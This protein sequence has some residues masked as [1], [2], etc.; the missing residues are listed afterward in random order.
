MLLK[1]RPER[2]R[3]RWSRQRGLTPRVLR[4]ASGPHPGTQ[5]GKGEQVSSHWRRPA[6]QAGTGFTAS[7]S[8][9]RLSTPLPVRHV[10]VADF[11][12]LFLAGCWLLSGV[13]WNTAPGQVDCHYQRR[14]NK[15]TNKQ[16]RRR[17]H[18]LESA[19]CGWRAG[20]TCP[21]P[22]DAGSPRMTQR[23]GGGSLLEPG[24][25]HG[26]RR[27]HGRW[28]LVRWGPAGASWR[29]ARKYV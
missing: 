13:R 16:L 7:C 11:Q 27:R 3:E 8:R 17:A 22:R 10:A 1:L 21:S 9:S 28:R 24:G 26:P 12:L 20:P 18:A 29:T 14:Q 23:T 15:Q 25:G 2:E 19:A 4:L 5:R 6:V